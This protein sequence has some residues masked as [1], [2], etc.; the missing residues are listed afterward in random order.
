MENNPNPEVI[1][2]RM[3]EKRQSLTQKLEAIEH[4]VL[5]VATAV[6]DTVES[7]KEGVQDTVE[8]VKDTVQDTVGTVKET[9]EGT[10]ETVKETFNLRRQFEQRPWLMLGGSVGVGLLLGALLRRR[11]VETVGR[12]VQ[13]VG[14]RFRGAREPV[15]EPTRTPEP[16]S[17]NGAH[18]ESAGIADH[19][20]S[21]VKEGLSRVKDLALGTL[22][23]TLQRVLVRELPEAVETQVK[24]F[25]DDAVNRLKNVGQ[26]EPV[27][28]TEQPERPIRTGERQESARQPETQVPR[29]PGSW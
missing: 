8:A 10:V 28:A 17:G 27:A 11:T 3:A 19:L 5:G 16:V 29:R 18:R 24:T 6:T 4:Q 13:S 20:L 7:V 12:A 15:R 21:P 22:F 26:R 25:L 14:R 1:R 2:Q 9:V 23:G